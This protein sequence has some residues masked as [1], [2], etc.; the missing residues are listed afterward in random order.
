M[1][2]SIR[3]ML[4]GDYAAVSV[5]WRESAGVGL[6]DSDS[7]SA[8][9]KFLLRNPGMSAVAIS[10][11]G[12]IVGAV[13]CGHDGRRGYLHHLAVAHEY[14]HK[15]IG[16]TLVTWCLDRLAEESILKCNIVVMKSNDVGAAFWRSTGWSD[17][18]DLQTFQKTPTKSPGDS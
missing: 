6:S 16:S 15:R 2:V 4:P 10:P 9:E 12:Q 7:P 3:P 18:G 11:S 5:L 14:Q 1:N 8:V 17:R 13:L